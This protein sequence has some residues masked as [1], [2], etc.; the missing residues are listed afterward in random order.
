MSTIER[1]DRQVQ[2]HHDKMAVLGEIDRSRPLVE[3]CGDSYF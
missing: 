1:I 2:Q 3:L